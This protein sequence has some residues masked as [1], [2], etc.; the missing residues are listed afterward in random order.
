M[1]KNAAIKI[2]VIGLANIATRSL[3]PAIALMPEKFTLKGIASRNF[4]RATQLAEQYTCRGYESYESLISDPDIDAV[5]IPLPNALHFKFVMMALEAGKH[6]LVEKSLGCSFGEVQKMVEYAQLNNLVLIENF[7]FR[8]HSQLA[9]IL[10]LLKGGV[11]GDLRSVRVSFGF[12]PFPSSTNIRYNPQLG[13]GALLDAGAY[14]LKIAPIFLGKEI[15]VAHASMAYDRK[16][17]ID[18]WGG[19]FCNKIT[20][21]FFV[22]FLM[23]LIIIISAPLSSGEVWVD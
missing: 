20:A 21:H 16:L 18:T 11:I 1:T 19:V 6:V 8:F 7:Q 10:K 14:P 4:S 22:N 2:G 15:H 17:N 23:D 5:Y 3:M 12:P 13:G 9:E